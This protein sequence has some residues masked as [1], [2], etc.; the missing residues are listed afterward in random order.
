MSAIAAYKNGDRS[1]KTLMRLVIVVEG[2]CFEYYKNP[3][4]K[5]NVVAILECIN[6]YDYIS[7]LLFGIVDICYV[8]EVFA[9]FRDTSLPTERKSYENYSNFIYHIANNSLSS[10]ILLKLSSSNPNICQAPQRRRGNISSSCPK[11]LTV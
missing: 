11:R 10:D 5:Q 1:K 8:E 2:L 3:D 6:I 7:A 9:F 4:K